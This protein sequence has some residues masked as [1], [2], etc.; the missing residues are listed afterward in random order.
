MGSASYEARVSVFAGF[1]EFE[2]NLEHQLAGG[3]HF[4]DAADSRFRDHGMAVRES[5]EGMHFKRFSRIAI[6]CRAVVLPHR[7]SR[8]ICFNKF[9]P[10]ALEE[11]VP[12]RQI[13][14]VMQPRGFQFA[15]D[16][17]IGRNHGNSASV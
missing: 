10:T 8:R 12:V 17:A 7:F 5:F 9:C 6:R 4:N 16:G 3:V 2:L 13:R 14:N 1:F 11:N 15:F